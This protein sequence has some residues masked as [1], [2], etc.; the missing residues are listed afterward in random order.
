[1]NASILGL[2]RGVRT[3]L[4]GASAMDTATLARPRAR[5]AWV[6]SLM[7]AECSDERSMLDM[8]AQVAAGIGL[9]RV[10]APRDT[11]RLQA[12]AEAITA[13]EEYISNPHPEEARHMM[14]EARGKLAAIAAGGRGNAVAGGMR[15]DVRCSARSGPLLTGVP[16]AASALHDRGHEP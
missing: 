6:A 12:V 7:P 9:G 5:L 15:A 2:L 10:G 4:L 14:V 11:C 1:M 16:S 8:A 3:E 13:V